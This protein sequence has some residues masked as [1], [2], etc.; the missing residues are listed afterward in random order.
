MILLIL[1]IEPKKKNH[2]TIL[3]YFILI[4]H[5]FKWFLAFYLNINS[6]QSKDLLKISFYS[7]FV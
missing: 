4:L 7:Q 3:R 1:F 5:N 6:N 2:S